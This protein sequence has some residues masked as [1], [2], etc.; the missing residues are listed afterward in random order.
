MIWKT[1]ALGV[2]NS[3]RQGAKSQSD[4]HGPSS[5]ANARDL[6]KISPFGRN[7]NPVSFAAFASLR[8]IFR[9]LVAA[10]PRC[11]SAVK[12]NYLPLQLWLCHVRSFVVQVAGGFRLPGFTHR[13][14]GL[15]GQSQTQNALDHPL[16]SQPRLHRRL[17][18][19][20]V[21]IQIGVRIG[22]EYDDFAFGSH[23]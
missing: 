14:S 23:P 18:E 16:I 8:E 13:A 21:A 20:I 17:G 22:F 2:G 12:K 6:R 3:S 4:G 11:P 9:D 19:L 5:R 15:P 1:K 7:D 10:L